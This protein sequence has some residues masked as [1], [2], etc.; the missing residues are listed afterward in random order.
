MINDT[1]ENVDFSQFE[2]YEADLISLVDD[3]GNESWFEIIDEANLGE[4]R[5]IALVPHIEDEQE[6]LESDVDLLIMRV[7][8]EGE[9]EHYDTVEDDEELYAISDVFANRLADSY[10]ID[11]SDL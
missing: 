9:F 7:S 5:Y 1:N 4:V 8:E 6:M 11:T 10:D 2:E 3:E